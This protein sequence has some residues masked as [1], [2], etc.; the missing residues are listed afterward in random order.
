MQMLM[1]VALIRIRMHMSVYRVCCMNYNP[2]KDMLDRFNRNMYQKNPRTPEIESYEDI[3]E[4]F[5]M[6]DQAVQHLEHNDD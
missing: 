1:L 2:T 3:L 6:F 5:E 4:A